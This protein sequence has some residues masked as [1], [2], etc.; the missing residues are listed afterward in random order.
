MVWWMATY[1]VLRRGQL[2]RRE[3]GV[4]E[5]RLLSRNKGCSRTECD[6]RSVYPKQSSR[7]AHA[8]AR[9][10]AAAHKWEEQPQLGSDWGCVTHAG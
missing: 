4:G 10:V 7:L 3:G 2:R 1:M 6:P 8:R 9:D 5:E